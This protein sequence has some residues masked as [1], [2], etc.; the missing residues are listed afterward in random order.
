MLSEKSEASEDKKTITNAYFTD[1]IKY[2]LLSREEEINCFKA[3]ANGDKLAVDQIVTANLRFVISIAKKY[4]SLSAPLLD[5]I[6]E[7]N[8][9]LIQAVKHFDVSRGFC[10]VSYAVWWIRQSILKYLSE[11]T[12]LVRLPLN[13]MNDIIKIRKTQ[14]YLDSEQG[15][16]QQ[17]E[18]I[19]QILNKSKKE[20]AFLIDLGQEHL[21]LD[22]K[23]SVNSNGPCLGDTLEDTRFSKPE[24]RY[25]SL[26]LRKDINKLLMTLTKS[27]RRVIQ[28]RFG[29]NGCK[30]CSYT[31][32]SLILGF[33]KE[34]VRQTE[35][36]AIRRLQHPARRRI[37]DAYTVD[38]PC[39]LIA[40]L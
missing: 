3:I 8:I 13:K 6:N 25:D 5:L 12:H 18:S 27:E 32:V 22:Q 35:K 19:A 21:S 14:G 28:M 17:L 15:S 24:E 39:H 36:N 31:E 2:P 9:G 1:I 34:K 20:V 7:G 16:D 29:L 4:Q 37:L 38:N 26:E 30:A 10:F 33:S 23:L 11:R 40:L